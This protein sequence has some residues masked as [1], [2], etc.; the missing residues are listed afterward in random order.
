MDAWRFARTFWGES[1]ILLRNLPRR[2]LLEVLTIGF[3][4]CAFKILAGLVLH[5]SASAPAA[6]VLGL[7]LIGLGGL[8][9]L[10]NAA[11]FLGLLFRGHRCTQACFF[12]V[13]TNPLKAITR[14]PEWRWQDL[15]NSLD[16]L[17]SFSLVATMIAGSGLARLTPPEMQFWNASVILNVMGA[18]LTRLGSS[19][20]NFSEP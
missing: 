5:A 6:R 8:D 2:H 13:L 15:G 18:G 10:I 14:H 16:V 20:K 1:L 7:I 19:L 9:A 12:S 11:N 17:T 4:F 3:P